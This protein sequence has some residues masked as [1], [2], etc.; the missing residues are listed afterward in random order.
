MAKQKR[1]GDTSCARW[2]AHAVCRSNEPA[3]AYASSFTHARA[4][5]FYWAIQFE[6]SSYASQ[7]AG[8]DSNSDTYGSIPNAP[9]RYKAAPATAHNLEAQ[10]IGKAST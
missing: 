5:Q 9:R 10:V 3:Y 2:L 6:D 8:R 7:V 1:R 4:I